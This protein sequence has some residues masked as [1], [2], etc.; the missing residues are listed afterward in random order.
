MLALP[1]VERQWSQMKKFLL[2]DDT[3]KFTY[4]SGRMT[5]SLQIQ[6]V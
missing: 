5:L 6:E 1:E 3:E 4:R 2:E